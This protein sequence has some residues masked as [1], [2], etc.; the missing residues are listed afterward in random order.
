LELQ[1]S[2]DIEA[3][4][5]VEVPEVDVS[6]LALLALEVLVKEGECGARAHVG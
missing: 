2:Q 4:I 6:P 5:G 3:R 1:A